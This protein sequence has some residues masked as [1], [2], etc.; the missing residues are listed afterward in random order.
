MFCFCFSFCWVLLKENLKFGPVKP[1]ICLFSSENSVKL[2]RANHLKCWTG[3][4][5]KKQICT[6]D[7]F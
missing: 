5:K 4:K 2:S 3:K 1:I 6:E 7:P